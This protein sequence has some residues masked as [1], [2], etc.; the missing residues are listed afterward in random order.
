MTTAAAPSATGI[1]SALRR[2]YVVRFGFALVWAG[3]LFA[4]ASSIGPVSATLLVLYP[5]FDVAAAVVDTRSS[6]PSGSTPALYVN[7]VISSLAA[8][9]LVVAVTSGIPA[10]LRVWGIWAIVS[11]LVQ[12]IVGITRRAL[13]GQWAMIA[14]GA[15][16]IVAGT[17]F[18]LQASGNDPSLRSMAGYALLGGVFFLV[19]AL[20]LGRQGPTRMS[21]PGPI[22]SP[23]A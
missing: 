5:L 12:L 14:S 19:A 22:G 9:G 6:R 4:T 10:V 2:L 23:K 8:L 15:I 21:T 17:A 11:G 3:L 13:G 16:S 20:R 7:I 1:A 18:S